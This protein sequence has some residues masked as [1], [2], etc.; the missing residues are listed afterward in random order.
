MQDLNDDIYT[1]FLV[2]QI[3]NILYFNFRISAFQIINIE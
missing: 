3:E 2:Q 1:F